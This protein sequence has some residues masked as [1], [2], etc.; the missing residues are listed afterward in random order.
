[1]RIRLFRVICVAILLLCLMTTASAN[2]P[3]PASSYTIELENLP[4]G[5][6]YVDLLILLLENDP[7]YSTLET[8]NIPESFGENAEILTYEEDGFC[9][10]TFH[11]RDA[12]ATIT[13]S[14]GAVHF[15]GDLPG[16]REDVERRGQVKLA[17]LDSAGNI[18]RVSGALSLQPSNFLAVSLGF[19]RYDAE[20][21]CLV[22]NGMVTPCTVLLYG[23]LSVLGLALTVLLEYLV[24]CLFRLDKKSL[25]LV[26]W[27]N[28]ASQ[29]L[30]RGL[31][32]LLYGPVFRT[33]AY[34]VLALEALVYLG[35]LSVYCYKMRNQSLGRRVLFTLASN[36]LSLIVVY[37]LNRLVMPI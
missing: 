24:G 8:A 32:L 29:I 28:L 19:F 17:M 13:V 14:G 6:V 18:L 27:V 11:Y 2:G 37:W 10:Y 4:E 3:A 22:A 33:Y 35:E 16:Q 30:L 5:T 1:M 7:C 23:F 15:F 21:D 31:F 20:E 9:S 34:A 25:R 36:T 12:N 26:I